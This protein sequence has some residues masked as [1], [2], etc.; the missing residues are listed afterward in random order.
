MEICKLCA[1]RLV[2]AAVLRAVSEIGAVR[3]DRSCRERLRAARTLL[4]LLPECIA[5]LLH[6]ADRAHD[7]LLCLL[8]REALLLKAL[9]RRLIA[10]TRRDI[11]TGLVVVTVDRLDELRLLEE[12]LG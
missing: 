11:C 7:E 10:R 12:R 1:A 8:A 3:S 5:R 4:G 6:E 9:Y 2:V